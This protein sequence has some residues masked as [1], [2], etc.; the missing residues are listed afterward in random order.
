M[1]VRLHTYKCVL[2]YMAPEGTDIRP[3]PG[4]EICKFTHWFVVNIFQMAKLDC[5]DDIHIDDD[6]RF[7]HN[8]LSRTCSITSNG[9]HASHAFLL[10]NSSAVLTNLQSVGQTRLLKDLYCLE[11]YY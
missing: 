1:T 9:K 5:E 2:F 7:F 4:D 3:S 10:T 8:Y 11:F 6:N